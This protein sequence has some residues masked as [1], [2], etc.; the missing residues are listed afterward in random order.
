MITKEDITPEERKDIS[1]K[2]AA[3]IVAELRLEE[4]SPSVMKKKIGEA[5]DKLKIPKEKLLA[6]CKNIG[7]EVLQNADKNLQAIEFG[8]QK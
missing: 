1:D 4:F 3:N 7:H 5:S 2:I 8:Q 6:Y